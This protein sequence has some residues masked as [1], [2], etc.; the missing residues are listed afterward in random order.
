[1]SA[2]VRPLEG[3]QQRAL[4]VLLCFWLFLSFMAAGD[5]LASDW[6][7]PPE[8]PT[9]E[10][11]RQAR[12][13]V[14]AAAVVSVVPPLV[15]LLLARRWRSAGWTA[16]FLVGAVLAVLVPAVLLLFS[17]SPVRPG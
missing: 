6:P 10:Q 7:L 15:G 13:S 4:G 16:T 8:L 3:Y 1:M 11:V 12:E 9:A 5:A 2:P 14:Q 17:D